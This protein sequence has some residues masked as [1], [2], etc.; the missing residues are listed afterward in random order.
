[1]SR[2]TINVQ[3]MEP[4]GNGRFK[5]KVAESNLNLSSIRHGGRD[6]VVVKHLRRGRYVVKEDAGSGVVERRG[7]RFVG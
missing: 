2:V 3:R 4:L 7:A 1:M 5:V 6:Y